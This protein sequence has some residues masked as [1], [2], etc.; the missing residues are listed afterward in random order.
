MFIRYILRSY[1]KLLKSCRS[2]QHS[3]IE[4]S[5]LSMCFVQYFLFHN[6]IGLFLAKSFGW[7]W[8]SKH[9][10]FVGDFAL[11]FIIISIRSVFGFKELQNLLLRYISLFDSKLDLF[12]LIF[13]LMFDYPSLKSKSRLIIMIM[14]FTIFNIMV[15]IVK[16]LV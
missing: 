7:K 2:L 3:C 8:N 11:W 5:I 4:A 1:W 15:N 16:I 6:K 10:L 12:D 13:L 14:L 9:L